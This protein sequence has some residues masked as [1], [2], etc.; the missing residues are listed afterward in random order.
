[1]TR[2]RPAG[3]TQVAKP[4][5]ARFCDAIRVERVPVETGVFGQ[6]TAS[7]LAILDAL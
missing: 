2:A 1:L 5:Y 3:A 6:R 4:I 7:S